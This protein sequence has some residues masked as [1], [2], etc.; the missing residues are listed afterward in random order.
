MKAIAKFT[1]LLI[2]LYEF[3][4]C[5]IQLEQVVYETYADGTPKIIHHYEEDGADLSLKKKTFYYPDGQLRMEGD[6]R[7]GQKY[8][9]W[10]AYYEDGRK[11]SEGFFKNG[12]SHGR[13]ISYHQNGKKYYEGNYHEGIRVG[14][15]QFYDEDGKLDKEIDYGEAQKNE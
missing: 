7:N 15:W 12:V 6:Y 8:G 14:K 3:T 5:G 4:G 13:T 9:Y 10:I 2:L 1:M 11:W